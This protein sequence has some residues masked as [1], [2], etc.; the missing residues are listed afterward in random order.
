MSNLISID[1]G[2]KTSQDD[3]THVGLQYTDGEF[4]ILE[5]NSWGT[6]ESIDGFLIFMNDNGEYDEILGF[7]NA[8]LIKKI[9]INPQV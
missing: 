9:V 5:S 8:A 4:E 3:I 2:K 1:G 7:R 6:A